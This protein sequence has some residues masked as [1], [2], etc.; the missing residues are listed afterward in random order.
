MRQTWAIVAICAAILA[1][2][3][4]VVV[5]LP[6]AGYAQVTEGGTIA[7]VRIEGTQR[8]DPATVK[9]YMT[10]QPGDH[11]TTEALNRTV[12]A[13]FATGL[14]A[15]VRLR[16]EGDT[17]IVKVVENPIINRVAFEG[18]HK[19]SDSTLRKEVQEKP[20][21]TF[22]RTRV[23]QDVRRVLELYR[24]SGR[25]A[26]TVVPQIIRLPQNRVDLI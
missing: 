19:L 9:S 20:R 6:P 10:V 16:R 18:N 22:T 8:I 11:F 21:E 13:L 15:D 26:A 25:F 1:V 3:I 23:G 24:R 14:F 7:A 5:T 12:K 17:L 2:A 4:V